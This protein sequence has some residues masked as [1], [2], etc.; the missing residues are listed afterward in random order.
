LLLHALP[1]PLLLSVPLLLLW[2]RT[3]HHL[4]L[5][6]HHLLLTMHHLLLAMHHLR[7]WHRTPHHLWLTLHHLLLTMHHLRLP[8]L[9]GWGGLRR[10]R[11]RRGRLRRRGR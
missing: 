4:W 11:R 2:H 9:R 8:T 10:H 6:L 1:V 3:P 5:T 7:L